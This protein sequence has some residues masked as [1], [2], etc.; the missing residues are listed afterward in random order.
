MSNTVRNNTVL[1]FV[2]NMFSRV[3]SSTTA[4][5]R[6]VSLIEEKAVYW[7]Y[8]Q[9]GFCHCQQRCFSFLYS[10]APMVL[11]AA[12]I[13]FQFSSLL[14]KVTLTKTSKCRCTC[15][16]SY[17]IFKCLYTQ[18]SCLR[19]SVPH[20]YVNRIINGSNKANATYSHWKLFRREFVLSVSCF[21]CRIVY[22]DFLKLSTVDA[23]FNL[24]LLD[25]PRSIENL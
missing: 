4:L 20:F 2:L 18:S 24:S 3:F 7:Q 8:S 22:K 10:R 21:P 11:Q 14:V 15:D 25:R 12:S 1:Q 9:Q 6:K 16:C 23:K 19:F 13:A 17:Y 5:T